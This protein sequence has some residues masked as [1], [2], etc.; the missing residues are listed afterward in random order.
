MATGIK[1]ALL[2][3]GILKRWPDGKGS[4]LNTAG[5]QDNL[6]SLEWLPGKTG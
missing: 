6:Q 2:P 4:N 1:E 3:Q 5:G